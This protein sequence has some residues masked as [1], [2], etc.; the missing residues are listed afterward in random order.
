[1]VTIELTYPGHNENEQGSVKKRHDLTQVI[2]SND[3]QN[4]EPEHSEKQAKG[5][6]QIKKE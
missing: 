2:V 4:R 5:Q 6:A 1:M 3:A